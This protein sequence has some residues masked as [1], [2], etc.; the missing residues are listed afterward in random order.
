MHLCE[1]YFK[2]HNIKT[3]CVLYPKHATC[4]YMNNDWKVLDIAWVYQPKR[5]G[6]YLIQHC[7]PQKGTPWDILPPTREGIINKKVTMWQDVASYN[8]KEFIKNGNSICLHADELDEYLLLWAEGLKKSQLPQSKKEIF[9]AGWQMF[10]VHLDL[11]ILEAGLFNEIYP[12]IDFAK[13]LSHRHASC[14]EVLEKLSAQKPE[15]YKIWVSQ[16][17]PRITEYS[18]WLTDL[19]T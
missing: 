7:T 14:M 11:S 6:C 12:S 1:E 4:F 18:S 9:M 8:K 16:F 3:S 5:I 13:S 10:L 17:L 2:R 19:V 15:L